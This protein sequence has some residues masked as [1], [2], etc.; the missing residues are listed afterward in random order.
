[1][2]DDRM[3][4]HAWW[5][6]G[7][8][9]VWSKLREKDSCVC[10]YEPLHEKIAF[11][12]LEG[13]EGPPDAEISR[14]Y[15]H[16]L[17]KTDYFA[18]Y[19]D[20]I[21]SDSLHFSPAL[22]HDRYL[23]LPEEEDEQLEGYVGGLAKAAL[24][25]HR[26]PVLCFCRSQMR[27]AW[28]KAIFGGIHIALI[29]NPADQ[30][31]SFSVDGYFQEKMLIIAL[32]LRAKHPPVFLHIGAFERFAR[33]IAKR[34]L[35]PIEHLFHLFIKEKD[36]LAV[37]LVIWLASALQAISYSDYVLDIDLLSND[38]SFK[39]S[40]ADW[41]EALGISIDFSDCASP[42]SGTA[43][44]SAGEFEQML[45]EAAAAVRNNAA[46][47]VIADLDVIKKR[48]AWVSPRSGEF[49]RMAVR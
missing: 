3:F 17:Q 47:L 25:T 45:R 1:M 22:S 44:L 46:S 39:K 40:A 12:T 49:L 38:P 34:P 15:R 14:V 42:S 30:W 24:A 26:T 9:Y 28:M 21:R 4:I 32:K 20:L 23:L 16:P 13:V 27:S 31:A 35:L 29:R 10:Y 43:P 6:S 48:L 18:E 7:S 37:F 19:A 8:T 41:F 5:R 36:A 11:L 33:E 2:P